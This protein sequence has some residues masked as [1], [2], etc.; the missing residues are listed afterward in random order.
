MLRHMLANMKVPWA[1]MPSQAD[2][3]LLPGRSGAGVMAALLAVSG[4]EQELLR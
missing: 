3:L 1:S 4:A 2:S